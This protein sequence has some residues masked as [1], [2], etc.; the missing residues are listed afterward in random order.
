M[1]LFVPTVIF[2]PLLRAMGVPIYWL[3]ID[4]AT[5]W[6]ARLVLLSAGIDGISESEGEAKEPSVI[7]SNH[8]SALGTCGPNMFCFLVLHSF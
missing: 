1:W 5:R 6:W 2:N 7:V 8:L 3:P 4:I